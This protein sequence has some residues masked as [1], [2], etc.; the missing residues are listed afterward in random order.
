MADKHCRMMLRD[1]SNS[2]GHFGQ[3]Y[4]RMKPVRNGLC[5]RH[6][7]EADKQQQRRE[8]SHVE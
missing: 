6:A 1:S 2:G 4:C 8:T 5:A 3:R 7:N